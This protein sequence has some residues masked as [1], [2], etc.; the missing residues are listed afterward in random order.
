[1]RKTRVWARLLGLQ[2]AVVEDVSI[3]DEKELVVAVSHR[4]VSVIAAASVAGAARA[5][6]S[7]TAGGAGARWI[8]AARRRSWRPRRHA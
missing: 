4:G 8:S 7:A 2:R 1:V 3:G 5:L 6:T